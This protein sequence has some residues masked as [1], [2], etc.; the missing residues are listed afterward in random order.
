MIIHH[1]FANRSNIGDWLSAQGIQTLLTPLQVKEYLCDEPFVPETMKQLSTVAPDDLIVIGGGGLFSRYFNPFWTN[2]AEIARRGIPYCIWGIGCC[3]IKTV[4]SLPPLEIIEPIVKKSRLCV[5]RDEL[6]RNYLGNCQLPD[7]VPCPTLI[8]LEGRSVVSNGILHVDHYDNIG[9]ENFDLITRMM[10]AHTK[11]TGRKCR[12][13]NNLISAGN[14][15]GL[16]DL[17]KRYEDAE[18]I[19]TSRLHGCIIGLAIGCKV[20]AISGDRKVESFMHA[21]GLS[22]W[23]CD[24]NELGKLPGMMEALPSQPSSLHFVEAARRSN[25][26]VANQIKK[27]ATNGLGSM[28]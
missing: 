2:F 25:R 28:Q 8:A 5:V 10:E 17:V 3:D 16:E 14:R 24:L 26:D 15:R 7:A 9:A 6:T 11:K 21:A 23:A 27:M 22:D 13:T 12:Q 18:L 20:L 4:Q 1:I 19:V